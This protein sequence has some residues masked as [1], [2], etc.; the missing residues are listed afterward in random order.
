MMKKFEHYTKIIDESINIIPP[1]KNPRGLYE[2]IEYILSLGGKR[3][4]P[5]LC[6]IATS[7]FD[8]SKV[9]QSLPAALALETFHNFTLLHDD[10]MDNSP[11]RR[12]KPTVHEK[13]NSNV[14][15]LSG[16]A[17]LIEAYKLVSQIPENHLLKAMQLFNQ[18]AVEVCEGQQYDMEFEERNDVTISDY[19]EMI[20]LKT[21]VLI[22]ASLKLGAII[23]GATDE[24]AQY[25]YDFGMNLGIS[26]QLQD[27]WLDTFG[28]ENEFGK[29]IGQDI[30]NNKKTFLLL[31]A[32]NNLNEPDRNN[33][34]EWISRKDFDKDEKIKSVIELFNKADVSNQTRKIMNDFYQ[35][36]L[37]SLN[38][39]NT[40]NNIIKSELINFSKKLIERKR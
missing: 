13:W 31:Y 25:M 9:K 34:I 12:N 2:P 3:I 18:T 14:A 1:N 40:H 19:V 6:L 10:I 22:G 17:M 4:R 7:F 5:I 30:I 26:F 35:K 15:I 16:D 39:I 33:L 21:G 36:S 27:D 23:G 20:R 8:E 11:Q 38:K 37:D 28:N 32:L 24:N 29:P